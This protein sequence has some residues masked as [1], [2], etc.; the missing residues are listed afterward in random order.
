MT[1]LF[2]ADLDTVQRSDADGVMTAA[3][4]QPVSSPGRV[5][6]DAALDDALRPTMSGRM[7]NKIEET[8]IHRS[9][10]ADLNGE[11]GDSEV[12]EDGGM[13]KDGVGAMFWEFPASCIV[14]FC[15]AVVFDELLHVHLWQW[16]HPLE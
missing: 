5:A 16:S 6:S 15:M 4:G 12:N 2:A 13:T 3:Y 11:P 10:P 7:D 9:D 1:R 8:G 14:C